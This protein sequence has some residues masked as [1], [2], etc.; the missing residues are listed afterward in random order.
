[1]PT[2]SPRRWI[3]GPTRGSPPS[4][5][6]TCSDSAIAAD[7]L[8]APFRAK[9]FSLGKAGRPYPDQARDLFLESHTNRKALCLQC[10][11][12]TSS[13]S[14][15]APIAVNLDGD[16]F[17][18]SYWSADH[19]RW[20][21]GEET[22]VAT[23]QPLLGSMATQCGSILSTANVNANTAGSE[24]AGLNPAPS[25]FGCYPSGAPCETY[26]VMDLDWSLM[27]G[28]AALTAAD[29]GPSVSTVAPV[30]NGHTLPPVGSGNKAFAMA[31]AL[32]ATEAVI[33]ELEG[34]GLTVAHGHARVDEQRDY[35]QSYAWFFVNSHWSLRALVRNLVLAGTFNMKSPS[36]SPSG[37]PMPMFYNGWATATV[38]AGHNVNGVGDLVHRYSVPSMLIAVQ[39]SLGWTGPTIDPAYWSTAYP[40]KTFQRELGRYESYQQT[41]TDEAT[42]QG[43]LAWDDTLSTCKNPTGGPDWVDAV[44]TAATADH[45]LTL[46]DLIIAFKDR[47]IQAPYIR[48]CSI[49]ADPNASTTMMAIA[50][51]TP[52]EAAHAADVAEMAPEAPPLKAGEPPPEV[53]PTDRPQDRGLDWRDTDTIIAWAAQ[54][55]QKVDQRVAEREKARYI[56]TDFIARQKQLAAD[57]PTYDPPDPDEHLP[58]PSDDVL[59]Q[60]AAAEEQG[61]GPAEALDNILEKAD[62]AWRG[63]YDIYAEEEGDDQW[64]NIWT[65]VR[66]HVSWVG[67]SKILIEYKITS[68]AWSKVLVGCTSEADLLYAY[69]GYA[70]NLPAYLAPGWGTPVFTDKLR[71]YCGTLL[72]SPQFL[73]GGMRP[74]QPAADPIPNALVCLPAQGDYCDEHQL[75]LDYSNYVNAHG[76]GTLVCPP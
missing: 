67:A 46:R 41:A 47:L 3:P 49:V 70:L 26:D 8:F 68:G 36:A 69:F 32:T 28:K 73:L 63:R 30:A 61:F 1:M 27:A 57:D 6:P 10:H 14:A 11:T 13:T 35:L 4:G 51:L 72:T 2:R 37:Y 55:S 62:P 60:L 40:T 76:Y 23:E 19:V 9:L 44:V 45:T 71:G 58:N 16:L 12:S 5:W 43:L 38:G 53:P 15:I 24:F 75:C 21:F 25:T 59:E 54:E 7:N 34:H 39:H 56:A 64:R 74:T 48:D 65:G 20:A 42:F 18:G 50:P 52:D 29:L 31:L 17:S 33:K 66:D 22:T